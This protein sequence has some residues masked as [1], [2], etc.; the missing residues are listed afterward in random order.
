MKKG[1]TVTNKNIKPMI[2]AAIKSLEA[3]ANRCDICLKKGKL[4]G[5]VLTY[6]Q[7]IRIVQICKKCKDK[8][9]LFA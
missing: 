2:E 9:G 6:K 7:A 5:G 3:K 1:I 8:Y 4:Y